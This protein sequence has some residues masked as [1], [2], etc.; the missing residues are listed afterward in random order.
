[1][2]KGQIQYTLNGGNLPLGI[3]MDATTGS[4]VGNLSPENVGQGPVWNSPADGS[5]L[6]AAG[7]GDNVNFNAINVTARPGKTLQGIAVVGTN[8]L[9][10]GLRIDSKTGIVSG[11][12]AELK[13]EQIRQTSNVNP[14]VWTTA[15]GTLGS[16]GESATLSLSVAATPQSNKT[17]KSYVVVDGGLP[18]GLKLE[19]RGGTIS[20]TTQEIKAPGFDLGLSPSVLTP[21][22]WTT[23]PGVQKVFSEGDVVSTANQNTVT[24]A[25]T[26]QGGKSMANYV[27]VAGAMPWGLTLNSRTG[28]IAGSSA[29]VKL[30]TD[31]IYYDRSKD[32]ILSD[33][34]TV[35]G[36]TLTLTGDGKSIGSFAK[37]TAVTAQLVVQPY[38]GRTAR[39]HISNGSLPLGL[40]MDTTGKITGTILSTKYMI[41]GTY[42]FTVRL[43]DNIQAYSLRAYSIT[44]Q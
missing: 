26:A 35:N 19:P 20:G 17:I 28:V 34:V 44:V 5:V 42:N 24:L 1:M 29:E 8:P 15:F 37:G 21:P 3:T 43:V 6:G 10:W 4:L 38:A 33:T 27:V 2:A 14:P 40:K 16:Y 31:P 25:A 36:Q 9:P 7:V 30:S 12:I 23:V 22:L 41:S 32:P 39:A 11:K 18:W 13:G